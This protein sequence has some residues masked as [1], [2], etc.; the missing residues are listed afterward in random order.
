MNHNQVERQ[1]REENAALKAKLV[2]KNEVVSE[3]MEDYI[4]LKKRVG[5]K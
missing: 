5:E 2:N 4:H 3:L 1:L